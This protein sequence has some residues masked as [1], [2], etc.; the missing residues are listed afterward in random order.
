[1]V[2]YLM[3]LLRLATSARKAGWF[4]QGLAYGLLG[5]LVAVLLTSLVQYNF[6]DSEAMILFWFLMGLAFALERILRDGE[7][8]LESSSSARV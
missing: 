2:A 8:S 5:G 1:M 6:G 3:F 7:T 4:P